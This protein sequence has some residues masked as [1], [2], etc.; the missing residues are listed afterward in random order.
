MVEIYHPSIVVHDIS[1]QSY[2]HS[3]HITYVIEIYD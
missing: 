2:I 1:H 3:I